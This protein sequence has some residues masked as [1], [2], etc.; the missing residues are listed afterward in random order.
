M[1]I[2]LSWLQEYIRLDLPPIQTAKLLTMA[3][4][5]VDS[6][7]RPLAIDGKSSTEILF[8]ISLTPNLGHCASL[9]GI[10]RELSTATKTPFT[11]PET[12]LQEN[13]FD[14][15]DRAVSV[16]VLD[17]SGCPRYACR[18]I[19]NVAVKDSPE[20]LKQKI[21]ACGIRSVNNLVDAAHFV[22]LEM[23]HPLH[24]FDYDLLAGKKIIVRTAA[25]NEPFVSLDGK[26][27]LL[28]EQD[29]LICDAERPVALAGIIGGMNSEVNANTKN[30]LIEAAYFNPTAI[31]R[32]SKRIGLM[33]EASKRFERG[34][35]PNG[36]IDVLDRAAFLV[37]QL[38]GGEICLGAADCAA[39]LFPQRKIRCRYERINRILGTKLSVGEIE[40][41]FQSLHFQCH[42][43]GSAQF[44]VEVP[45]YR[46]DLHDEIDLIEEVARVYGFD[47]ISQ[48]S[49][50]YSSSLIPNAPI[51]DFER[52]MRG[53]LISS[54]LQEFLTCDL[55]GPSLLH[56]ADSELPDKTKIHVL[57]PT[58]IEQSILRTSLL[59]GLLN[60]VKY[61][62]D[63][64]NHEI[65]GF[66]IGR[67]HFKEK[68]QYKEQLMAAIVLSGP[69][70][71]MH[72]DLKPK[73]CDFYDLKGLLESLFTELQLPQVEYKAGSSPLLH[74][75]RQA[76][77]FVGELE[78][79]SLGEVHPE[80]LRRLDF[81]RPIL[82]AELN[83]HE[84][85]QMRNPQANMQEIPLYPCSER[86]L[87]LTL[88]EE[89]P[90]AQVFSLIK[91]SASPLLE[92]FSLIDIY[93]SDKL[94]K[95]LKNATLHFV[96][97]DAAKTVS[98]ETVDVEHERITKKIISDHALTS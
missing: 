26:E 83:L 13:Q 74:P 68:E 69:T 32:T 24:I 43:D 59:P 6:I 75:G 14:P 51:F 76:A 62:S 86:D 34:T 64:Q 98:Q 70:A 15:V 85:F 38:A 89:I 44:Y 50:F 41:M 12:Q 36:L 92:S 4:L 7:D 65:A 39:K 18:V 71:P 54:G 5:E 25:Q 37:Q 20:W 46:N 97:R 88:K 21:E 45:T 80:V 78:I 40:N 23:G 63:R 1:K 72:W 10:A 93:R 49:T 77:L 19:R 55:V 95:G 16:E 35:D 42:W 53:R 91:E 73:P 17:P 22:M 58:S 67:I 3:G 56:I 31:R 94:G 90:I 96:Y 52:E 33:T 27:H 82:F 84:L 9:I 57:N 29:L 28:K 81:P 47:N 66:E 48:P 2:P 87:T 30:I 11:F 61:N 79:G 60:V 8:D